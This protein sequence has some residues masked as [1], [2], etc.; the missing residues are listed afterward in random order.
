MQE[1]AKPENKKEAACLEE[2]GELGGLI[3]KKKTI[4]G[5]WSFEVGGFSLVDP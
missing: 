5:N 3:V 2:R 1:M 4:W